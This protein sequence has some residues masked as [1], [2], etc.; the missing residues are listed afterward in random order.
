M[1]IRIFIKNVTSTQVKQ[2]IENASRASVVVSP[3]GLEL[4][5]VSVCLKELEI[6]TLRNLGYTPIKVPG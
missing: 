3:C 6:N 5:S 1:L 2:I 4:W